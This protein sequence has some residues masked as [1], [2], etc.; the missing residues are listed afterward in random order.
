MLLGE[1]DDPLE[2]IEGHHLGRGVVRKAQDQHLRLGPGRLDRYRQPLDEPVEGQEGY[3][4][5]VAA[6]DD[7]RVRMYGVGGVRHEDDVP[8]IDRGQHEVAD[9][10]LRAHRHDGLRLRVDGDLVPPA[11]PVGDRLAQL[12]Y[13]ARHRVAVVLGL[14]AA[15]TNFA[16]MCFGVGMSGLPMPRSMMSSPLRLAS[17][18]RSLTMLN[19]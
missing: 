10:L 1:G 3:R 12:R 9:P 18:R 4:P 8:R 7:D 2:E 19:V 17:M 6:R 5:Q 16:T 13:A 15:S 11:I 14:Q